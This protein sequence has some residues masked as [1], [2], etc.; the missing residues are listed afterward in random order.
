MFGSNKEIW[1][2]ILCHGAKRET[3]NLAP[4]L[5]MH[6]RRADL[7]SPNRKGI[8]ILGQSHGATSILLNWAQSCGDIQRDIILVLL[9]ILTD[10]YRAGI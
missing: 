9:S 2:L 5:R 10:P 3:I 8:N 6:S 4:R 7:D 1:A